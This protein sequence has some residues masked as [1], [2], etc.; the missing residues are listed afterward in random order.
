MKFSL[1]F[2]QK[3]LQ[4]RISLPAS[5][6]ISNRLLIIRELSAEKFIIENLSDSDDTR[7]LQKGLQSTAEVVDI[8]HAGTAMRF[9][10]AFFAATAQKKIITGSERMKN[11]PIGEL[12]DALNSLGAQICYLE[13]DGYPPIRTSGKQISGNNIEISGNTS[14]QFISAL[15]LVAPVLPNGLTINIKGIP[16]SMPYINM[17]LNLMQQA[18]INYTFNNSTI[19]I[20]QQ[21]Y[22]SQGIKVEPDMSAASYWYQIAILANDAQLMLEGVT[23][24]SLQGDAI[25]SQLSRSFGV[26]TEYTPEGAIITKKKSSCAM[27]DFNFLD[28]PDVIQTMAVACCLSNTCFRFSGAQTLRIKE[29]DRIEALQ[30]ELFKLGYCIKETA[31]GVIQ[32]NGERTKPQDNIS[33]STYNDHRMAMAFAPAAIFFP[34]LQIEN[35]NVV[36]K[37]YP[38]FWNDLEKI[39]VKIEKKN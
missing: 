32:W 37:S 16:V 5:K 21:S 20:E 26:E 23:K 22:R 30:K 6:S 2:P 38:N 19:K 28:I 10:T 12:V 11:R 27:L 31:P 3:K 39:G 8:G 35:P 18:G 1:I 15:L 36:S 13:K 29:T 25:I 33:I 34:E 17:T 24:K 9:I 4:G 14:S 7:L